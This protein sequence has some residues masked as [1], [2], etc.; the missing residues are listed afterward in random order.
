MSFDRPPNERMKRPLES[1]RA[2]VNR[3]GPEPARA[4]LDESLATFGRAAATNPRPPPLGRSAVGFHDRRMRDPARIPHQH[5]SRVAQVALSQPAK[6]DLGRGSVRRARVGV[7]CAVAPHAGLLFLSAC[8]HAPPPAEHELDLPQVAAWSAQHIEGELGEGAWWRTMGDTALP[9]LIE[10]ALEHNR[11]LARAGATLRAA[12]ARTDLARA[13]RRPSL[14]AGLGAARR[15]QVFVGLPIPGA[16]GVLSSTST[17]FDLGLGASWEA[18]LWGRLASAERAAEADYAAARA[19]WVGARL[20]LVAQV[21][22]SW[23][24]LRE[25][26][27]QHDLA[28]RTLASYRENERWIDERYRAG[29]LSS[30][31]LRLARTNVGSAEAVVAERERALAAARRSLELL[32]GRYP[33]GE[34]AAR[35]AWT[36]LPPAVP[37][38]LPSDLLARR[39]DLVAAEARIVAERERLAAARAALYPS[40]ALTGD[41]GTLTDAIEDLLDGDFR[42]WSLAARLVQPIYDGGRRAAQIEI[43]D[44]SYEAV[45]REFAGLFLRACA[46]VELSLESETLIGRRVTSLAAALD[47]ARAA[48]E[49][50]REQYRGGLIGLVTVL[51]S[52]RRAFQAESA[53]MQARRELLENRVDLHLALGGGF[54]LLGGAQREAEPASDTNQTGAEAGA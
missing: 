38:G 49:V 41:A 18:D 9:Q 37:A 5:R 23:F 51:E 30:L 32:L 19:D 43:A 40:V 24:V 4:P 53:W 39:P 46:E 50:A 8:L 28:Q 15:R 10:E 22:K 27:L 11:D 17:S 29:L 34:L 33:A 25:S 42:V 26:E 36:D 16:E 20:A 48:V 45:L 14:D 35:G 31:D 2:D 6:D 13:G 1:E 52:E 54:E 44:A 7:W 47:D 3:A 21:A 12:A